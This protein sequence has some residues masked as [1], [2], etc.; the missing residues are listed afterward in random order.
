MGGIISGRQKILT[1]DCLNIMPEEKLQQNLD[2]RSF[3]L[4]LKRLKQEMSLDGA[5]FS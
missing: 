1:E 5:N 4:D 2:D 3:L